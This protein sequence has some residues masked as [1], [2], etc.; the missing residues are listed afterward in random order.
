M[1][2][3]DFNQLTESVRDH[4][5][6][7]AQLQQCLRETH[8]GLVARLA[9]MMARAF[10]KGNKVILCGNGGSASDAQHIAAEFVGRFRRER[11]PLPSLALAANA[12]AVTAIANDYGYENV[13]DRQLRAL[14]KPGDVFIVLTTSGRSPNVLTAAKSAKSLGLST[15]SL[16]GAKPSPLSEIC[17]IHVSVPSTVTARVQ[18]THVLLCHIACELVDDLLFGETQPSAGLGYLQLPKLTTFE[19]LLTVRD[20]WRRLG[21]KVVWTNGCFDLMHVGHVRNLTAAKQL[22]DILIVGVNSDESVRS[23]KGETR[24]IVLDADRAELI[25]ALACV[26]HVMIFNDSDP[27]EVLALLK[28]DV[29]TKGAEYSDQGR[30]M[31]EREVVLGYGGSI[32]YLPLASGHSTTNMIERI[33]CLTSRVG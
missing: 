33:L 17:D 7:A 25:S 2:S 27:T 1:K 11:M 23:I 14:A 20:S 31:P 10:F 8:A 6:A 4:L 15:V 24:P 3:N 13:F 18:E 28:P 21:L 16:T 9:A 29:H 19:D 32:E 26:D 30:H 22:G 5:F 12:A